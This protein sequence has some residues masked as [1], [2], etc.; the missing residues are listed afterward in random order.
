[1]RRLVVLGATLLACSDPAPGREPARVLV[2]TDWI[3]VEASC[4]Y[5]FR[6]PPDTVAHVATQCSSAG[7]GC[8]D[9]KK[10]LAASIETELVPIRR[11][12][13]ELRADPARVDDALATGAARCRTIADE[14]LRTVRDRM[15]F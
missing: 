8:I 5:A 9:C 13:E 11:R 14:T 2:F 6:A 7:W 4:G 3:R 12:A 10:V 1:M 15:G